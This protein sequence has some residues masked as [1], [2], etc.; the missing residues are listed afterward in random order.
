MAQMTKINLR[1]P[2]RQKSS[3]PAPPLSLISAPAP[4]PAPAT[5]FHLKLYCNSSAQKTVHSAAP[6]QNCWNLLK[7][8]QDSKYIASIAGN[9][10][11]RPIYAMTP[12]EGVVL[13]ELYGI[14]KTS[15]LFLTDN[16]TGKIDISKDC[17]Y[18]ENM[19]QRDPGL[20]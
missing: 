11:A 19:R 16:L 8:T 15:Q 5:F 18:S 1:V 7:K 6:W 12:T 3:A 2:L 20:L 10:M 4:A 14:E 17:I 13:K 9:A